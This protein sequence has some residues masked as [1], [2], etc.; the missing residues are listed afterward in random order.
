MPFVTFQICPDCD[1]LELTEQMIALI[2][3]PAWEHHISDNGCTERKC[4]GCG[5]WHPPLY[6]EVVFSVGMVP[7]WRER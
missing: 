2:G 6:E 7:M 3:F 4:R 5:V 1:F